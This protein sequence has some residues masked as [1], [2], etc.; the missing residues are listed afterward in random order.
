ME[1]PYG[2]ASLWQQSD[3]VIKSVA[4]VLLIMSVMTWSILISKWI[5]QVRLLKLSAKLPE[6]WAASD[7]Q[8]GLARLDNKLP[9]DPFFSL[10]HAGVLAKSQHQDNSLSLTHSLPLADWISTSL[11]TSLEQSSEQAQKGLTAL[12][13]IGATAPF[14]GLFGTVWGIY[15][16]LI[17]IGATGKA[18]IDQLAGPVGEALVMTAFGLLVAIPAV[19]AYNALTRSNRKLASRLNGFAQQ[20]NG[21]LLMGSVPETSSIKGR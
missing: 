1:N 10:V 19:L 14:V 5:T 17:K 7:I 16:A 3:F 15:H 2:I 9:H 11:Q 21:Y 20:L 6:F 13:S 18:G 8:Q 4:A 12:A